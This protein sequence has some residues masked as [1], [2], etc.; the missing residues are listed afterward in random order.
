MICGI[1]VGV[2]ETFVAVVE[3]REVVYL[4]KLRDLEECEACGIDAPLSYETPFRDCERE[5]L[6]MGIPVIPL[7]TPFMK[8]LHERAV[9]IAENLD[10]R[11]FEVYPYATR[12]LL[13]FAYNKKR[14]AEREMI[15]KKLRKYFDFDFELN[16]HEIDALTAALTVRLF[17]EGR[18]KEIGKKCKILIPSV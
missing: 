6:K 4:G 18:A 3:G 14:K 12:K 5:L 16:E 15:A 11:I 7:N 17:F 9:E 2:K 13:G 1:D 8:T 10:C